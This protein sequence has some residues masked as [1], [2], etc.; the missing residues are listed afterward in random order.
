ML[1]LCILALNRNAWMSAK[2]LAVPTNP[3]TAERANQA[4]L[5]QNKQ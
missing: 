2:R 4:Y 5:Y 1:E 3:K